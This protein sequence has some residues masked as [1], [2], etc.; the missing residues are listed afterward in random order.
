MR[1]F[2]QEYEGRFAEFKEYLRQHK[3]DAKLPVV[4]A[5]APISSVSPADAPPSSKPTEP[6]H[7]DSSSVTATEEPVPVGP[8]DAAKAA[9]IDR[10]QKIIVALLND[11]K[12]VEA[13]V[14]AYL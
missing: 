5:T 4:D 2:K 8:S 13:F 12:K 6:R 11:M 14:F 9:E 1:L 10:L 7:Q 3:G